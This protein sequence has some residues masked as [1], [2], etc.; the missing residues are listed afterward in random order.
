MNVTKNICRAALPKFL[1]HPNGQKCATSSEGNWKLRIYN[2]WYEILFPLQE[3]T[4][5]PT[6]KRNDQ[7]VVLQREPKVN[8]SSGHKEEG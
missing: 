2:L 7:L 8:G 1:S 4:T 3:N 6:P 5:I